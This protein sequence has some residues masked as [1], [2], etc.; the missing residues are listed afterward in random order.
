MIDEL[1]YVSRHLSQA[2]H[3]IPDSLFQ[4]LELIPSRFFLV[5]HFT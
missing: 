3:T 5:P 1:G 2:N 4:V